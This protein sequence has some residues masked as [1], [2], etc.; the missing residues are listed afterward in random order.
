MCVSLFPP[1]GLSAEPHD[2]GAGGN[3]L[4]GPGQQVPGGTQI[5]DPETAGA[6]PTTTHGEEGRVEFSQLGANRA[7]ALLR[8]K[9]RCVSPRERA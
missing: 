1:Q 8:D 9:C 2:L 3:P 5:P 6:D 4:S 7:S